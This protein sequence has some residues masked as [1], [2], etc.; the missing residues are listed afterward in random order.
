MSGEHAAYVKAKDRLNWPSLICTEPGCDRTI[1]GLGRCREHWEPKPEGRC[2]HAT[3][4]LILCGCC[5][6]RVCESCY[7]PWNVLACGRCRGEE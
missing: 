2:E 3:R 4:A 6:R 1:Y 5:N 7:G